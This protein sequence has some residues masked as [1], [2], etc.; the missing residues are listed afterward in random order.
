M[1]QSKENTNSLLRLY[2]EVISEFV[3]SRS[4]R[5]CIL[6]SMDTKPSGRK[7]T[8]RRWKQKKRDKTLRNHSDWIDLELCISGTRWVS[9]RVEEVEGMWKW[10]GWVLGVNKAGEFE[11]PTREI[12]RQK[13]WMPQRARRG[14]HFCFLTNGSPSE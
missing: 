2:G 1:R 11:N 8:D 3:S 14:C 6:L 5:E 10:A 4:Q 7:R 13:W 12:A 9:P